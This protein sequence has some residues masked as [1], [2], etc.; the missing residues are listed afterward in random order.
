GTPLMQSVQTIGIDLPLKAVVW[1]D[2]AGAT[3]L[4]Y[5]DPGWLAKRH[6]GGHEGDTAAKAMTA[7]LAAVAEAATAAPERMGRPGRGPAAERRTQFLFEV[8]TDEARRSAAGHS[9]LDI[10]PDGEIGRRTGDP[11]RRAADHRLA[12]RRS[13]AGAEHQRDLLL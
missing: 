4:S 9:R 13:W 10:E 12:W 11:A 7:A 8:R 6:R 3:W 2:A 5:N 1:Q